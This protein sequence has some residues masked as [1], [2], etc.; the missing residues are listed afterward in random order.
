M[1]LCRASK[2]RCRCHGTLDVYVCYVDV[3]C[4][5]SATFYVST[6]A[7]A[8]VDAESLMP[9][10]NSHHA[11]HTP[12]SQA[13]GDAVPDSPAAASVGSGPA[14]TPTAAANVS[15]SPRPNSPSGGTG[16]TFGR[17][18]TAS[19]Q[20]LFSQESLNAGEAVAE[21][22]PASAGIPVVQP[23]QC[24]GVPQRTPVAASPA[25]PA[26]ELEEETL[27]TGCSTPVLGR[28][29]EE[30]SADYAPDSR[31]LVL[32]LTSLDHSR[33]SVRTHSHS[34]QMV[35]TPAATSSHV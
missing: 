10:H 6:H 35:R 20:I 11:G 29:R 5:A 18:R 14:A 4:D 17:P 21:M 15:S 25:L 12:R 16:G 34:Q 27:S 23:P 1:L 7:F 32:A 24:I 19:R 2:Y 13:P 9:W 26:D 8:G 30:N 33:G 28:L 3:S 22:P 31:S